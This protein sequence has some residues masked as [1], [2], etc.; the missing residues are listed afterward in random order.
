MIKEGFRK[1]KLNPNPTEMSLKIRRI[2]DLQKMSESDN[3]QIWT[4]NPWPRFTW[5]IS[6]ER[7]CVSV[8]SIFFDVFL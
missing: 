8:C 7:E 2:S 4:P 5:K 1:R 3:I 6:I